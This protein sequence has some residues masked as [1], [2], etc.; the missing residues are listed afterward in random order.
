[1]YEISLDTALFKANFAIFI[2]PIYLATFCRFVVL[3]V[4]GVMGGSQS[5]PEST[6]LANADTI[7]QNK[8]S[9]PHTVVIPVDGSKQS[10]V[11]FQCKSG[12]I[13]Q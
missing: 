11:A 9:E 8:K 3:V 5:A 2:L 1:M 10:E 12:I 13:A 4:F 7:L 6:A